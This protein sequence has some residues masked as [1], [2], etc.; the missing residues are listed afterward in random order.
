MT[1][2]VATSRSSASSSTGWSAGSE[3]PAPSVS[4]SVGNECHGS[5]AGAHADALVALERLALRLQRGGDHELGPVE[6]GDV[7]VATG[8]HRGAQAAHEVERAVVLAGGAGDDL[9]ER[10][11]LGRRHAGATGQRRVEGRHAP[12][13]AV[14]RGLVG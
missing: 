6:L 5:A 3:E 13:E 10:P 8:G 1:S 4:I 14:P 9:L 7:L 11:V 2:S 12:V